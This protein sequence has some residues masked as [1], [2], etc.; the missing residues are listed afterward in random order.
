MRDWVHDPRVIPRSTAGAEA[1]GW[2]ALRRGDWTGAGEAFEQALAEGASAHALD[3]L[4]QAAWWQS[5][6]QSAIST[7]QRAYAAYRRVGLDA[8]AAEV[9]LRLWEEYEKSLDL[10]AAANGWLARAR[11]LLTG[12]EPRRAHAMLL[13][14]QAERASNPESS[15]AFAREAWELARHVGD[16]DLELIAMGKLGLAEISLGRVQEGVTHFDEAMAAASSGEPNELRTIGDLYCALFLAMEV[17]QDSSRFGQWTE[18]VM[19]FMQRYNHPDLLTFCGTCCAELFAVEGRW[20]EVEKQLLETMAALEASGHRARCVHP[21]VRLASLRIV[22]GRLEDAERLLS[23][24]ED[25]AEATQPAVS[26]HLARGETALAAARLHRRLNQVGRENLLAVPLLAQLI[27]VQVAQSDVAAA[28]QTAAQL[29]AIAN[30]SGSP[31]VLAGAVFAQGVV[32]GAGA[33]PSALT[34]IGRAIE[35]YAALRMPHPAA[36]AHLV[37]ARLLMTTDQKTAIREAKMALMAFEELGATRDADEAAGLLR[38]LGVGGRTGPKGWRGLSRREAEVL[39]L[40]ADGLT[41]AEIA[42]R[43]FIGTKTVDTHVGNILSK[44]AV[45]NRGEAAAWAHRNLVEHAGPPGQDRA[46]SRHA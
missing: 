11:D 5:Q 37:L 35:L 32:D 46:R 33:K 14:A 20:Q 6:T 17:I 43:L 23:G 24:V 13:L 41:N 15:L 38:N 1:L 31:R 26:L 8:D 28:V 44:L 10:E 39:R 2:E 27:D 21:S 19:G 9:A 18:I 40:L 45:R 12:L 36:R 22:Q 3:G 16:P 4:A 25:L 29:M 34:H 7:W 30:V 42:A